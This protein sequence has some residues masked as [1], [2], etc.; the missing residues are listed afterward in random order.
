MERVRDFIKKHRLI[1]VILFGAPVVI[2]AVLL[3]CTAL[4][5]SETVTLLGGLLSYYGTVILAIVTVMQNDS[6]LQLE[7][8]TF[9]LE[10]K[11]SDREEVKNRID[12]HPALEIAGFL[13]ST[14]NPVQSFRVY[15]TGRG[16]VFKCN[17]KNGEEM[18]YLMLK[19]T[20]NSTALSVSVWEYGKMA[21]QGEAFGYRET[22]LSDIPKG[23]TRLLQLNAKTGAGHEHDFNLRYK[24]QFGQW[25]YNEAYMSAC[26][27]DGNAVFEASLG[28]QQDG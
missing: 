24:N 3:I 19:N 14:E 5:V 8:R 6:I 26:F 21:E 1:T 13:D 18:V 16:P 20:G 9:E 10:K 4:T 15:K 25:F 7:K 23:E 27:V 11:S 12:Y 28:N 17:A 22:V 2:V